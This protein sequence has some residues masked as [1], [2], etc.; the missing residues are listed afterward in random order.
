MPDL[1]TLS[2][3]ARVDE[4]TA[5]LRAANEAYYTRATPTMSDAAYDALLNELR[6]L[7]AEHPEL[8]KVDSPTRTVGAAVLDELPKHKHLKPMI[9]LKSADSEGGVRGFFQTLRNFV[10][11]EHTPELV[12]EPKIDGLSLSLTY[13]NGKLT[14]ATTRGDKEVGE[15]V[16]HNVKSI[17]SIPHYLPSKQGGEGGLPPSAVGVMPA[18]AGIH[19]SNSARNASI[20]TIVEV[21]GEVYMEYAALQT[22]NDAQL[23]AGKPAFANTRNAAAGSLRQLDSLIAASRPLKFDAYAFGGW[24]SQTEGSGYNQQPTTNNVSSPTTHDGEL[25]LLQEWGFT[26]AQGY[27][28]V[29]D[30]SAAMEVFAA[31]EA[32]RESLPY[33]IDGLVYKVNDVALQARLGEVGREPRWALAHKFKAEGGVSTIEAIDVQV[34][35]SG[36]ITPVARLAPVQILGATITNAT[37]HNEDYIASRQLNVGDS[38]FVERAGDVIPQVIALVNAAAEG[39][40]VWTFPT[41][42]P[43]CGTPLVRE[44]DAAD[45]LCPNHVA[46]PAQAEASIIH[47]VSKTALDIDG[48]GEKQVQEFMEKGLVTTLADIFTLPTHTATIQQWEGY[49]ALSVANLCAAIEKAKTP[50]LPRFI[51]ALGIPQVGT[52]TA[53]DLAKYFPTWG[54]IVMASAA[55]PSL[56][57]SPLLQVEGVGPKVAASIMVF[58][59]EPHTQALLGELLKHVH[60]QRYEAQARQQGFFTGKTVVLTGTMAAMTRPEA[61]A[62]LEAQGAKVTGSVTSKTDYVI[63]GEEAGSKLKEAQR[64]GVVVLSESEFMGKLG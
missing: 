51:N 9:S 2:A 29:P 26:V 64:L 34:G 57:D 48:L 44:A 15:D 38:V 50:T 31:W 55:R 18:Q 37:L 22:V 27:K 19:V 11:A 20:P 7:E 56:Q 32:Q 39:K 53:V 17:A 10:G 13:E 60:P 47:A 25:R 59:N 58:L 24:V 33:A 6:R 1:F 16:L 12:V 63:A 46:C 42:C 52:Q 54:D 41:Q 36:K 35:R 28:V 8:A 21:R 61:K 45:W 30:E 40:A 5:L 3:A 62:R 49:G 23:A 43:R 14:H 4:L